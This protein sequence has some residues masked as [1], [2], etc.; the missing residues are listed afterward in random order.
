M[1]SLIQEGENGFLVDVADYQ[2]LADA[3]IN[4][5]NIKNTAVNISKDKNDINAFLLKQIEKFNLE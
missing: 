1:N 3:I 4:Y 5:K 2:Q